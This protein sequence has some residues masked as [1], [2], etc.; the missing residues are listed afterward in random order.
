MEMAERPIIQKGISNSALP[1]WI[2]SAMAMMPMGI[3]PSFLPWL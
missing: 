2:I 1:V 3:C